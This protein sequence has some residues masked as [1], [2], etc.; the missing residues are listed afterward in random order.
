[1]VNYLREI[2]MVIIIMLFNYCILIIASAAIITSFGLIHLI[3]TP[4]EVD[5]VIIPI[6]QMRKLGLARF[7]VLYSRSWLVI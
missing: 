7:S 2:R 3:L 1:M 4:Y 6:L 5:L